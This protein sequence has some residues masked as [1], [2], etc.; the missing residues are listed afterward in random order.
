MANSKWKEYF[1]KSGVPLEYEVLE[2]LNTRGCIAN[3]EYSYFRPNEDAIERE[4][5]YDIDA[6]YLKWEHQE[7]FF[8]LMIECKYRDKS[9]NWIFLPWRYGG[10]DEMGHLAFLHPLDIFNESLKFT[11]SYPQLPPIA[12]ACSKGIE[13]TTDGQNPKTITQAINQLSY[14]MSNRIVSDMAIQY[15]VSLGCETI[16]YNI[17]I[18][19]TTAN[20]YR[21]KEGITIECIKKSNELDEVATREN[22]LIM[23]T[24]SGKD[25]LRYS[26]KTLNCLCEDYDKDSLQ[27]KLNTYNPDLEF[28]LDNTAEH[29]CPECIVVLQHTPDNSGFNRLF[30][31]FDNIMSPSKEILDYLKERHKEVKK[32]EPNGRSGKRSASLLSPQRGTKINN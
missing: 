8:D 26:K 3:F 4:F 16:F 9:T 1:L 6:T 5:S 29:R 14:A 28:V 10:V 21:L 11:Y 2:Y 13:I 23:K 32:A 30:E 20:L 17:P 31:L 19:V 15:E 27:K 22:L 18:I 25:L 12:Q 24:N 7:H